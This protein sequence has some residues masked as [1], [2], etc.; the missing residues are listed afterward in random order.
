V[1]VVQSGVTGLLVPPHDPA[2]L[3]GAITTYLQDS[4]LRHR[5]GA[6]ARDRVL[7][8]F[9]PE[10]IWH[11]VYEVYLEL[12]EEKGIQAPDASIAATLAEPP[13]EGLDI[14]SQQLAKTSG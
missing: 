2:S 10:E 11:A 7:R 8:E 9:R 3:T 1:D 5:H 14:E 4:E 13:P 12:L 6:A